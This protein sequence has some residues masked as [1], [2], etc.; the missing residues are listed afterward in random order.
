MSE[1]Y[2]WNSVVVQPGHFFTMDGDQV[3]TLSESPA[4]VQLRPRN[5]ESLFADS[6][7]LVLQGGPYSTEQEAIGAGKRWRQRVSIAFAQQRVGVDLG[8]DDQTSPIESPVSAEM[9]EKFGVN[10]YHDRHGLLILPTEEAVFGRLT[11]DVKAVRNMV[12][13]HAEF[14]RVQS[15]VKAV[16]EGQELALTL[17]HSARFDPNPETRFVVLVTAIEAM[18]E[19]R[20]VPSDAAAL[21]DKFI[22]EVQDSDLEAPVRDALVRH[23]GNGKRES[24]GAA[25]RRLVDSSLDGRE[26]NGMTPRKFFTTCYGL[27]SDLVHGNLTRPPAENL[28]QLNPILDGFV[29]DLINAKLR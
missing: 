20:A 3:L 19:Q 18:V 2:F 26:Y 13:L 17:I 4:K 9:F 25:A 12:H 8:R 24:V 14:D 10:W 6:S 22:T 27:R 28:A 7:E 16:T 1:Y 5:R 15:S 23:M 21:I 29:L 11:A